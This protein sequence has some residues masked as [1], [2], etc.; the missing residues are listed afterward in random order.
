MEWL[1]PICETINNN[2]FNP[3][4][5]EN[6]NEYI[7]I[8][9]FCKNCLHRRDDKNWDTHIEMNTLIDKYLPRNQYDIPLSYA[10][11]ALIHPNKWVIHETTLNYIKARV[12][13]RNKKAWKNWRR[14]V[15]Y[16]K[17]IKRLL[18]KWQN[19]NPQQIETSLVLEY[20]F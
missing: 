14:K 8:N 13:H 12:Y 10:I 4:I 9:N 5:S 16:R 17:F 6:E 19:N 15:I 7:R 18:D 2:R 1:C 11:V 3:R 20:L